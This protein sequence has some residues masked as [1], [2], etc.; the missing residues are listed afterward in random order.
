MTVEEWER[1]K[2][3]F[4]AALEADPAADTGDV[5][6]ELCGGDE[7]LEREVLSLLTHRDA[8]IFGWS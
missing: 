3:A 7:V 8:R 4:A 2:T 6:R 5:V 1:I